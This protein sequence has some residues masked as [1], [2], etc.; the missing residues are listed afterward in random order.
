M[1]TAV[2]LEKK[3]LSSLVEATGLNHFQVYDFLKDERKRIKRDG[4]NN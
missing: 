2:R 3:T 4:N 1:N